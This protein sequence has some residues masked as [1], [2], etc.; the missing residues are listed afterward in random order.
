M[1][2]RNVKVFVRFP[3][4]RKLMW[5]ENEVTER[6][7]QHNLKDTT[8]RTE[9]LSLLTTD[10]FL[11]DLRL[12]LSSSYK[13]YRVCILLCLC[14][15]VWHG[16]VSNHTKKITSEKVCDCMWRTGYELKVLCLCNTYIVVLFGHRATNLNV[17][18]LKWSNDL[19]LLQV[20]YV[21]RNPKDVFTSAFHYFGST[22]FLVKPG[23]QSEFLQKFLDGE[24][25]SFFL[26]CI[27]T[28]GDI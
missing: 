19:S 9:D 15:S 21:M 6:T 7:L 28:A 1:S 14:P 26:L 4:H 27:R 25:C 5:K 8:T 16:K 20:I 13:K 22:S 17:E 12:L 23:P 11:W 2:E 24:G 3:P 10:S 18:C